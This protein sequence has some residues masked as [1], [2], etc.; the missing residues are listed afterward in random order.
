MSRRSAIWTIRGGTWM[1][2]GGAVR[3]RRG[4]F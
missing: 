4:R 3:R 2:C 1:C